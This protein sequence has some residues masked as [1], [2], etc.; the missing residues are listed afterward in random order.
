MQLEP[1]ISCLAFVRSGAKS[2]APAAVEALPP[3]R[4]LDSQRVAGYDAVVLE[5]DAADALTKWLGDH[6]YEARPTLTEWLTP[7]VA[8]HWKLTAFKIAA[9]EQGPPA[10]KAVRMSF[11]TERPFFPYREPSD[12]R[13]GALGPRALEVW[14]VS[15]TRSEGSIGTG[16][17]WHAAVKFSRK[18][19]GL[20]T[21]LAGAVPTDAPTVGAWLTH[22]VDVLSPRPG[23]DEV[24]FAPI[25]STTEVVPP[26]I[27]VPRE[28]RVF[29]PVDLVV[30]AGAGLYFAIRAISRR[31]AE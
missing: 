4:V 10:T 17:P 31:R 30:L 23:I 19:E 6:G 11:S 18:H 20:Q 15:P 29:V 13:V 16:R 24:Y 22:F 5:A 27:V 7:Y 12:Q 9:T 2:T 8:A 1:G 3:V 28:R 25:A 26:P 14:F 21:L